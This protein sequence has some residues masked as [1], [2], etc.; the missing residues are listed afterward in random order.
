MRST[1]AL[2][3]VL[4][5]VTAAAS[6]LELLSG[7]PVGNLMDVFACGVTIAVFGGLLTW[8]DWPRNGR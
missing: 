3:A 8:R 7:P 4:G 1:W 2:A 5:V 6:G